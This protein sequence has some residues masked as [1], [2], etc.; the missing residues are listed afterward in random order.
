MA[1]QPPKLPSRETE[2]RPKQ[3]GPP[4]NSSGKERSLNELI[5]EAPTQPEL[6]LAYS[7]IDNQGSHRAAAILAAAFVEDA[8]RFVFKA[9]FRALRNKEYE[10]IFG[11]NGPLS[12]FSSAINLGYALGFYGREAKSDL[13]VIRRVRNVFA[14]AMKP[15]TFETPLIVREVAKLKYIDWKRQSGE[16]VF[17]FRNS[18]P[19]DNENR[20]GYADHCRVL[21]NDVMLEALGGAWRSQPMTNR[22][23]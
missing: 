10:E 1:T 18:P 12:S 14:H 23:I 4:Q 20:K 17:I 15:I 7:E 11:G 6:N 13:H 9:K 8:L 5:R 22:V 3:P 21:I 2:T 19:F 16:A